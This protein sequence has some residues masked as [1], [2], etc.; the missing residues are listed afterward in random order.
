MA[1]HLLDY[2]VMA[3]NDQLE[4]NSFR[5]ESASPKFQFFIVKYDRKE[6]KHSEHKGKIK[7]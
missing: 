4:E 7:V 6:K 2:A 1:S 5:L 3:L